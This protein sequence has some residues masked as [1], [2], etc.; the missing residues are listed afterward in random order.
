M[1]NYFHPFE[2]RLKRFVQFRLG[3]Q[4]GTGVVIDEPAEKKFAIPPF[5][6][7]FVVK[8]IELHSRWSET[9]EPFESLANQPDGKIVSEEHTFSTTQPVVVLYFHNHFDKTVLPK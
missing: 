8:R 9:H 7:L 1:P 3:Y 2:D 6:R 4:T 5:H